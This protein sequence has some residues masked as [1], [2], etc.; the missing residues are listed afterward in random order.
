MLSEWSQS[1]GQRIAERRARG[2]CTHCGIA[3][4]RRGF[5]TCERCFRRIRDRDKASRV[6]RL[7]AAKQ[8]QDAA[9]DRRNRARREVVI[10]GVV[11]IVMN[12]YDTE[13]S[14]Q[15]MPK[16]PKASDLWT[17]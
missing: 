5:D 12:S 15:H 7:A 14:G 3:T 16:M 8:A 10:N 1:H 17:R 9:D 2:L 13:S 6:Q 11:F 4:A